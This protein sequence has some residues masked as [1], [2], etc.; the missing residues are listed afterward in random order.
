MFEIMIEDTFSAA[1]Q[2]IGYEGPCENLHG[3]TW[4]VSVLIVGKNLNKLGMLFDFKKAKAILKGT[5]DIFDHKNLND[6]KIF[7]KINPTA[8]NIAKIIYGSFNKKS[9]KNK[10]PSGLKVAKTTVWESEVTCATYSL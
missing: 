7:K 6:L 2:L 3:H 10:L 5:T 1:H 8:E 4:K 9:G